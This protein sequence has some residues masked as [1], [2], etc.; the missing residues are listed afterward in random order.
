VGGNAPWILRGI[1]AM[2]WLN[3]ALSW[4]DNYP[5][6]KPFIIIA[7][8]LLISS[9]VFVI[10]RKY[11][12][13]GL[14]FLV[15]KSKS[16]LDDIIFKE[17]MSKRL[18]YIAALLVIHNFSDLIPT[19]AE[20]IQRIVLLL[21]FFILIT[22]FT[23]FLKALNQ[24]YEKNEKFKGRPIKGYIQAISIVTYILGL[25]VVIGILTRQSL[26]VVLSS[27][28]ALTAVLLLIFK[29][30]ILSF[31]ASLEIATY[32]L[33]RLKD[34]I[35]A[36]AFNA[37]GDVI[38]IALHTIKV[39]NFDKTI[40]VIPTSKLID[41]SFK[42]W[43]GM[44]E[45]GG[46]RIKRSLS[47]DISSIKFCDQPMIENLNKIQLLKDYLAKKST[48]LEVDNKARDIDL[49]SLANG[50]R[51]TNIGTFR[52]YI[53]AYLKNHKSIRKD[54]TF[55]IRQLPPGPTGLPIEI[56]VFTNDT[57]WVNYEGI[58]SDIFDHFMAVIN[59][60]ELR[61]FQYPA[62]KDLQLLKS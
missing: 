20:P 60:F 2:N 22:A 18:S 30:T 9:I 12:V 48:E 8:V 53:E 38:D 56:Y 42:N 43:R 16:Q 5:V 10:T 15:K 7:G 25:L 44:Q 34:W 49:D 62:G 4:L 61:V 1:C 47:I 33:V 40:S 17:V 26:V 46:R 45:S 14:G 35:E 6:I 28:G 50:R 27:V 3:E 52:A 39:Q 19:L 55:L 36:P 29:D 32:D 57:Q 58:Q 41:A 51:L 24:V 11:V 31:V 59:E 23:S 37:D 13:K 54:F 21:I